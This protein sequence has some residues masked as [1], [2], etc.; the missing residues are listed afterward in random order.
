VAMPWQTEFFELTR[1]FEGSSLPS[2]K[3][4]L[5]AFTILA[6]WHWFCRV[7]ASRTTIDMAGRHRIAFARMR[8][9]KPYLRHKQPPF[10]LRLC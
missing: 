7:N 5:C 4:S 1:W 8:E 3:S 6:I 10:A 9:N 2:K